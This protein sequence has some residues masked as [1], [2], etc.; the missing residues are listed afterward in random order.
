[1]KMQKYIG[2]LSVVC[3]L[4]MAADLSAEAIKM[5]D[6]PYLCDFEDDTEN[7]NW[8]LNP[9]LN[10]IITTN[11][12]TVSDAVAYTGKRS[13]YVSQDG[14]KTNTYAPVNNML[15][16]Y[17]DIT[18]EEGEYDVAYDWMGTGN[19]NAGYLKI[20]YANRPDDGLSC[21]GNGVEP[22]WVATSVQL[23]GENTMLNKG[24]SWRH[25]QAR[26]RIPKAQANKTT[27]RLL[28][29]WVNT[30]VAQKDSITSVAIDNFQ[31]AKASSSDYPWNIHISTILNTSTVSWD[32]SAESYEVMYRKKTDSEF[33]SVAATGNSVTLTDMEYGAYE[34]W[35]CGVNGTDKTVYTVFPVVYIYPTDCFDALNMYNATFEYGKWTHRNGRVPDG[36]ERVDYGPGD[37]RSR[38]T[39]HFDLTEIDPRTVVRQGR[40]TVA[41]LHTVP[42]GE[43]GS[44]RLGNWAT[45]SQY[46]SVTFTYT[47]EE[48]SMAVLLIQYAIVLENPN[49]GEEEQPRFTLEVLGEDG[50]PIDMECAS[51]DFHSPTPAEWEDPEVR[52]LWHSNIWADG[53]NS[54]SVIWQDWKTIG[55][56]M[57]KYIGQTLTIIFTSY[58]CDQGGHFGYAY[59]MLTCT[60]SD[61]DGLPWGDGATTQEFT[62]PAG[63]NYAWFDRKDKLFADTLSEE[64]VFHV[65][66]T[67][68]NTYLCHVTYSTNAACGYWLEASAKLHHVRAELGLQWTPENCNNAYTWTNRCHLYLTNQLTGEEEHR[69]DI[70]PRDCWLLY[71]DG[72]EEK[73]GVAAGPVRVPVPDEGGVVRIGVCTQVYSGGVFVAD[74]AW[75]DYQVP[76]VAPLWTHRYDSICRGESVV[77]PEG[78]RNKYTEPGDY[79]DSLSSAVTGCDSVVLLHLYVHEPAMTEAYDTVCPGSTYSFAGR[80]LNA[81]GTYTG[82]FSSAVTGCDSIVTLHL[83]EAPVP[84]VSLQAVQLCS[85][86]PL[87]FVA[88]DGL[89]ADSMLVRMEGRADTVQWLR[90]EGVQLALPLATADVGAHEAVVKIYMPWCETVYT[91]TLTYNVSLTSGVVTMHWNDVLTF[92]S[93]DHNGGLVFSSYQWYRNGEPIPGAT[94]A[95]YYDPELD[96]NAEYTVRVTLADGSEAWVCPFVPA[97][98]QGLEQDTAR[99]SS[100]A[101]KFIRRGQLVIQCNNHEYDAQG[102]KLK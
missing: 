46:E 71:P 41:C 39:T 57:E 93:P 21:L 94:E 101:R 58:D 6:L 81:S 100:P 52:A 56:S 42:A 87:V 84:F 83:K 26:V 25:V 9:A 7:A 5:A 27:T 55:I 20:V 45:G 102:R 99:T 85:D 22:A 72:T 98:P 31:L 35:I 89:Y 8:T 53:S 67:D 34:F 13:L 23:M 30:S 66:E 1:M 74:T 70:Q 28:F 73:I 51:V 54:H 65:L 32:G 82:L 78:S 49:H 40:D 77:F 2:I 3:C 19:N 17:R 92:Y 97:L 29:V 95:Y 86:E 91:D 62:A 79:P 63:F 88:H 24:D 15:L 4:V 33:V 76:A 16:A 64:R 14:G 37:V 59:F 69:Y 18:L 47:V 48:A 96:L 50:K 10:T 75:Y 61:V 11:A 44:L 90:S 36:N 43:F 80:T 38:H 60:R 12:W 68:T